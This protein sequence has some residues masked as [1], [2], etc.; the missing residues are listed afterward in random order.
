MLFWKKLGNLFNPTVAKP[1]DWM[2]EYAQCPTPFVLNE[3]ILRVYISTRPPR[4]A[5]RQYVSHPGYVDLARDD[6]SRVVGISA[7]PLMPLGNTGTFDEFGIMPSSVVRKGNEVYA[8]YTGWTRMSS[9]PYTVGIGMAI[10]RDGGESFEKPGEGPL[11]GLTLNEPYLANSPVVRVIGGRWHMWYLS[12]RK[13]LVCDGKPEIVFQI[14]HATS[15]DGISWNRD[16]IPMV[17]TLSEDECQDIFMP[18]FLDDQWH[19]IFAYRKPTGFRTDS[20]RA[21]RL[22]YASSAD[23]VTWNRDDS[24]VGIDVSP[25][26]WDSQ[27]MCS[28]QVIELDGRVLLFYCGNV[29]G[30]EGFGAAELTGHGPRS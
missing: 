13:W 5:D 8:Y 29:F 7:H 4:G 21:Y 30:R 27:M 1:R 23:L 18:F 2:Q 17:P 15:A 9:V 22:G 10:S 14:V 6:I 3:N 16:G 25:S 20:A 19:A 11:L 12:G 24:Q 28:S 26:G